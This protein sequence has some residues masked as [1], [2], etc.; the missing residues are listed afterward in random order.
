MLDHTDFCDS[1]RR[2]CDVYFFAVVE[3]IILVLDT[4]QAHIWF[5]YQPANPIANIVCF[6][7]AFQVCIWC[8]SD[9]YANSFS[10]LFGTTCYTTR[11]LLSSSYMIKVVTCLDVPDETCL[12]PVFR[13][14]LANCCIESYLYGISAPVAML[15]DTLWYRNASAPDLLIELVQRWQV[16]QRVDCNQQTTIPFRLAIE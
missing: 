2:C 16:V 9:E 13:Y 8:P 1:T 11:S 3:A 10:T 4:L 15:S 5:T 6:T 14:C 7:P 12:L